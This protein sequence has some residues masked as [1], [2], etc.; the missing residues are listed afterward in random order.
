VGGGVGANEGA[1]MILSA[2]SV[3]LLLC[4]ALPIADSLFCLS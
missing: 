4:F 3:V 2:P 1:D